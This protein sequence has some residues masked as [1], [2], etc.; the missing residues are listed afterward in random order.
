MT[1]Q[2]QST[3]S[4]FQGVALL[5][6]PL[7]NLPEASQEELLATDTMLVYDLLARNKV[8]ARVLSKAL[9]RQAPDASFAREL[10]SRNVFFEKKKHELSELKTILMDALRLFECNGIDVLF[11]K[12]VESLPL[13]SDNMDIL[14]R[15]RDL[16]R[17]AKL[18]L[19]MGFVE[20]PK[21][22]EPFKRLFRE[23]AQAKD[24]VAIHLHTRVGWHGIP[25]VNCAK[26]WERTREVRLEGLK[27]LLPSYEDSILITVAHLFFEN[28]AF[29]LADLLYLAEAFSRTE[30]DWNYLRTE[31]QANRFELP[32]FAVL[33]LS[34]V[35][36]RRVYKRPLITLHDELGSAQIGR[37]K[38]ESFSLKIG[39]NFRHPFDL[40]FRI[41]VSVVA[42]ELI[43]K[44]SN[45]HM[46]WVRKFRIAYSVSKGYVNRR[47]VKYPNLNGMLVC[48]SGVDGSGKTTHAKE[49]SRLLNDRHIR[50]S[51]FWMR[52]HSRFTTQAIRLA[53]RLVS[54]RG[55]MNGAD[56]SQPP[57]ARIVGSS[58]FPKIRA[59]VTLFDR[60][61]LLMR[62]DCSRLLRN[63]V[64][65][66][67]YIPDTIMDIKQDLGPSSGRSVVVKTVER[68]SPV[69]DLVFLLDVPASV[70]TRRRPNDD[71]L[72]VLLSKRSDY[73]RIA[74]RLG[75]VVVDSAE[76]LEENLQSELSKVL[77][78][79][80]SR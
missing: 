36:H 31:S 35:V 49:L 26:L 57:E 62:I 71:D 12:P 6:H 10:T 46:T 61:W 42:R 70:L 44:L 20:E 11:I 43:K 22:R 47:L 17:S 34:D 53:M 48:Y 74:D 69:P 37:K 64:V 72:P 68:T 16:R 13:D 14:I 80:Y 15:D 33:H 23:V 40:P 51:Y 18:L 5:A 59:Y 39:R 19:G 29:K 8:M 4:I 50:T 27:V 77:R 65:C 38:I 66:D 30:P 79:Y 1:L 67:R 32:L 3:S 2:A 52:G 63:V 55:R 28:L 21:V 73:L 78:E 58:A 9:L 25:F 7:L 54:K 45:E 41:P 60:L 24:H 56:W 75:F 76:P